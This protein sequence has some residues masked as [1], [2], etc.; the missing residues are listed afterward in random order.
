MI[1][2]GLSQ[3]APQAPIFGKS[4]RPQEH[5]F[6]NK[7]FKENIPNQSILFHPLR[8]APGQNKV[9]CSRAKIKC[10]PRRNLIKRK[11][12]ISIPGAKKTLK[13]SSWGFLTARR[14]RRFFGKRSRH[15]EHQFLNKFIK[16]NSPNQSIPLDPLRWAPS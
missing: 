4:N 3:G 16:E 5:Q 9:H 6:L 12:L 11:L 7:F 8:L 13:I 15:Q 14:R 1:I 2:P 10:P